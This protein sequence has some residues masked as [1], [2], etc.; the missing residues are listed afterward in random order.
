MP[1][2]AGGGGQIPDMPVPIHSPTLGGCWVQVSSWLPPRGGS[3]PLPTLCQPLPTGEAT[4]Q[5][6]SGL[7][8]PYLASCCLCP[9]LAL[10]QLLLLRPGSAQGL[11]R[12][13]PLPSHLSLHGHPSLLLTALAC[14]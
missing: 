13:R 7:P 5:G 2:L 4:A 9:S 3:S 6:G 1:G 8:G 14:G 10:Q 12:A 11:C